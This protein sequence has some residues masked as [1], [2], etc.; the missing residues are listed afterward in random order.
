MNGFLTATINIFTSK[1]HVST[2]WKSCFYKEKYI[3]LLVRRL[4]S[5]TKETVRKCNELCL[6]LQIC[7]Y[8]PNKMFLLLGNLFPLLRKIAFTEKQF[9]MQNHVLPLVGNMFSLMGKIVFTDKNMC[10]D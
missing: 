1:E 9:Y 2:S 3:F 7:S 5:T 10:F 4:V 6:S 8:F